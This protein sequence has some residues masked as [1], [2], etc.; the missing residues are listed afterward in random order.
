MGHRRQFQIGPGAFEARQEPSGWWVFA[1]WWEIDRRGE[2]DD[3]EERLAGPMGEAEA[4]ER[5]AQL[6]A[7]SDELEKA[8]LRRA[9]G[10]G[11]QAH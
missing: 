9:L 2:K 4:R 7:A 5:A 8:E 11:S 6:Q 1:T 3:Q 10:C